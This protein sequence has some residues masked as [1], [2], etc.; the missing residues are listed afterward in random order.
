MENLNTM[1]YSQINWDMVFFCMN[2]NHLNK[3]EWIAKEQTIMQRR[4]ELIFAL[5][6]SELKVDYWI[7][8]SFIENGDIDKTRIQ[9]AF[10]PFEITYHFK[11]HI[12]QMNSKLNNKEWETMISLASKYNEMEDYEKIKIVATRLKE[13]TI[14]NQTDKI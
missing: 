12:F 5:G 10:I 4:I 8:K 13:I 7:F 3:I 14:E 1:I 9:I 2:N 6:L 11:N